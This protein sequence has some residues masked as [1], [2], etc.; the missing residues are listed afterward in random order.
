MHGNTV[1]IVD[2]EIWAKCISV[3]KG[4]YNDKEETEKTF[5]DGWFKT[6]DLGSIDSDN[7]IFI[8]GRKKNLIILNNGKNVSAEELEALLYKI[9]DVT[10][11]VVYGKN[12]KIVAE[13]FSESNNGL[14]NVEITKETNLK[15]DLG[16]NSLD[17]ANLV[18][19]VEDEFNIEIPD[20]TIKDLKTIEDI[21]NL[22]NSQ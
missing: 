2:G 9:P 6:G 20:R 19:A 5:Q 8:S 16:L 22:I 18:C 21:I 14:T 12:N 17:L 1:K 10:E 11:A 3:S 4:Y 7:F 15:N 13:I